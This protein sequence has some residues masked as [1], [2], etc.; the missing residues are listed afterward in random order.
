MTR[1]RRL[2][3]TA[4]VLLAAGW[5]VLLAAQIG[6]AGGGRGPHRGGH[7]RGHRITIPAAS[8]KLQQI[9][10]E[11][12]STAFVSPAEVS[13][14][15]R[16][17]LDPR[18]THRVVLPAAGRIAGVMVSAGDTVRRGQALLAFDSPEAEAA[19]SECRQARAGVAQAS[20]QLRLAGADLER[21]R[22]LLAHK[23]VASKEV[24]H[25]EEELAQARASLE[26]AEARHAQAR[27]RVEIFGLK[28]GDL[29]QEVVV[30]A[31]IAGK[32]L[33]VAVTPGEYRNDT[34]E[35]L[36][37]IA[38]MSSVLV[39]SDVAERDIRL[40]S[41][42]EQVAVDL[43]AYPGESFTGRVTRIADTVD[44]RTRTVQVR[45]SIANPGGRLRPEMY[46][47]IRHSHAPR[48]LPVVPVK[49][50]V[51][52]TEGPSVFVEQAA[53]VFE[54]RAVTPGETARGRTTI[55]SGLR[56]GDRVVVD[57]AILLTASG[58]DEQ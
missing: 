53:G 43:V 12:V 21:L 24:L 49:A 7:G 50:L 41:P 19:M 45:A 34:T 20:A 57:G 54:R 23:A 4:A 30:R 56:P 15:G 46:G 5:P 11:A 3:A 38:D 26:Q 28:P 17:A 18:R 6:T 29:G 51:Q 1:P 14:P 37:T 47:R 31:A 40:V 10:T 52:G 55:L 36:M 33:D 13:A 44:P 35:T 58:G 25:A 22:D 2:L 32:V 39:V 9:R 16:V 27:R 8:P 42:G 48:T